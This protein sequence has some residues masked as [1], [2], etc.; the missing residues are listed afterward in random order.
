[1]LNAGKTLS[2]EVTAAATK[3]TAEVSAAAKKAA[4]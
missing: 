2:E 3:A 1:M 4:N